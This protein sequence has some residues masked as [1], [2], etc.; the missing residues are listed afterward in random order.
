MILLRFSR[1]HAIRDEMRIM[2][3]ARM[4]DFQIAMI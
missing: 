4:V 1:R 2:I 3:A